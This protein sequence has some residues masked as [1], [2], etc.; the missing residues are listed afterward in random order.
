MEPDT[1][2]DETD[3]QNDDNDQPV[4]LTQV[5]DLVPLRVQELREEAERERARAL[6]AQDAEEKK[7]FQER[8]KALEARAT[9]IEEWGITEA[10]DPL[11]PDTE[12]TK[13]IARRDAFAAEEQAEADRLARLTAEEVA[14]EQAVA[15]AAVAEAEARAK[16]VADFE[17]LIASADLQKVIHPVTGKVVVVSQNGHVPD[18]L[19]PISDLVHELDNTPVPDRDKWWAQRNQLQRD[20]LSVLVGIHPPVGIE[21]IPELAEEEK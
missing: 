17:E 7:G 8:F 12:I 15:A 13:E 1:D 18:V 19:Q 21:Q 2:V 5:D 6:L 14:Q 10:D 20:A 4:D 3:D 9:E 11:L 16:Q